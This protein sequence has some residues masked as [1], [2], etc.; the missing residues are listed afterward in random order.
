MSIEVK[1][2]RFRY[3]ARPVIGDVSFTAEKGELL[4]VLGPNGVGKSTLFRCLLGFLKPVGGEILVDGKELTAYSRREL[5]KKIAYI[6]QSHTPAFDHTV[7]DSVLMGM[8][9]QL[10]VFEQPGQAQREKAMQMLRAL[11]IEKLSSRGCMKISGGERQ[12]MLL[13]RALV[14]DASMLIMDEP[15]ANL[16]YGN[17][18]R[19]ME[20]VKKLGQ[21]GYTIIFSTHNMS[22]VEE[23]CDNIALIN[24]SQVVLS[25]N[26]TEVK[27]RFRTNNFTLRFHTGSGKLQPIPEMFS[28][29]TEKDLAGTSEVRIHKEPGITN[30]ALL[31]A[32]A[33]Q[34]EIISFTE[35]IPSMNDIFINTVSGTNT[36][37]A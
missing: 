16:D 13:A 26:V 12:L 17:S 2:L 15:T 20:R 10:R 22:S 36:T 18:C 1:N 27:S 6:P 5:A 30:S 11:G 7:L 19:V 24:R 14:Q 8:T 32:L 28:L 23:I 9:A 34:T 4:A 29:L 35:E 21:T 37:Q 25:G 33:G 31:S 3:G